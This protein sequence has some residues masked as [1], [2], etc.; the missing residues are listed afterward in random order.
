ML[1]KFFDRIATRLLISVTLVAIIIAS[2]S[3]YIFFERTYQLEFEQN[4]TSLQQLVQAISHTA[5]IATYLEDKVLAKEV[6]EGIAANDLVKAVELRA[7]DKL[8]AS[9]GDMEGIKDENL[10]VF[11]LNSPFIKNEVVGSLRVQVNNKLIQTY[12]TDVAVEHVILISIHS[13]VLILVIMFLLKYQFVDLIQM[14]AKKLHDIKPGSDQRIEG[15][16]VH[17]NDEIGVLANDINQLLDSVEQTLSRE[18]TLRKEVEQLE[19]RFRSI[20]EQTSGGIGLINSD[21]FLKVHNPS[22][23]KIMGEER[24]R[25]LTGQDKESLFSILEEES[26]KFKHAVSQALTVTDAVSVDLKIADGDC[27][28]WIHCIIAKMIDDTDMPLLEVIIQDVSER[29]K[30]EQNFK[31]QAELDSL[32][33]LYNRRAGKEKIQQKLDGARH[34]GIE[35]ALLMIDL[36]NFKPINDQYGHNAGDIVLMTVAKRLVEHLR[37]DDIVIRWGG[38]EIV[39]FVKHNKQQTDAAYI[40]QKLIAVIRTPIALDKNQAVNVG[41]SIGISIFPT[42]SANLDLLVQRADEAMYQVKMNS[43]NGFNLYS[44]DASRVETVNIV[45][46]S[47]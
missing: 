46:D 12:A 33:G 24:T 8:I 7:E 30:S 2:I 9:S 45:S 38:D 40:A 39:I 18:R 10:M 32:T 14:L 29:R 16:V 35:Y 15:D 21:G 4:R 11:S 42:N 20:F 23:E 17:V 37:S 28:R 3:S 1:I 36:D 34:L 47:S 26:L 27:T 19:H 41:A 43:K 13:L 25:R 31:I 6:I 44:E 22:F 5:A